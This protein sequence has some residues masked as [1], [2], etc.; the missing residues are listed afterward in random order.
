MS[1]K[2]RSSPSSGSLSG[3]DCAVGSRVDCSDPFLRLWLTWTSPIQK[4]GLVSRSKSDQRSLN[5]SLQVHRERDISIV[6]TCLVCTLQMRNPIQAARHDSVKIRSVFRTR[7]PVDPSHRVHLLA[8]HVAIP[9]FSY[10][11]CH[12]HAVHSTALPT[13]N[14]ACLTLFDGLKLSSRDSQR[15]IAVLAA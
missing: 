11:S 15:A 9:L 5:P 4:V 2:D 12:S 3:E 14:G 10:S 13:R 8:R 7:Y 1:L 6:C